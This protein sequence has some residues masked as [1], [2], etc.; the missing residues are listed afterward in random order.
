[1][2]S[3]GPSSSAIQAQDPARR[4]PGSPLA[5]GVPDDVTKRSARAFPLIRAGGLNRLRPIGASIG[6]E[7]LCQY[8]DSAA[9][10][11]KPAPLHLG[12]TAMKL[13]S[14]RKNWD[15]KGLHHG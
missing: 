10:I 3:T 4:F 14:E 13:G 8:D 2:Q 15:M 11:C 1:M 12:S 6:F 7:M 9:P 5:G